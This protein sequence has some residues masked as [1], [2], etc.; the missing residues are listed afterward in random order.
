MKI[1]RVEEGEPGNEAKDLQ[2]EKISN[3]HLYHNNV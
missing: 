3:Q 1:V 2:L